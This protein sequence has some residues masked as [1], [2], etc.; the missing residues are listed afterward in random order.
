MCGKKET[1]IIFLPLDVRVITLMNYSDIER[2]H[3]AFESNVTEHDSGYLHIHKHSAER[4]SL[5]V[6]DI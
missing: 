6:C 3:L 2:F 4:K 5:Y 1:W